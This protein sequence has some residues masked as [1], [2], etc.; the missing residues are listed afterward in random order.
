MCFIKVID[1][2]LEY[3]FRLNVLKNTSFSYV[4][5]MIENTIFTSYS[6]KSY[7]VARIGGDVANIQIISR[8]ELKHHVSNNFCRVT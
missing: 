5:N 6:D 1:Y 2:T 7:L 8:D 3:T 4:Q